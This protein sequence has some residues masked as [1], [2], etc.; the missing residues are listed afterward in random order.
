M[1]DY[2]YKT[3]LTNGLTPLGVIYTPLL[4]DNTLEANLLECI[5][6]YLFNS[7]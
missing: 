7:V 6:Y 4:L 5:S 3:L 2:D 1:L